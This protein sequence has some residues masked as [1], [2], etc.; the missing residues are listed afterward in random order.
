MWRCLLLSAVLLLPFAAQA[1]KNT[2]EPVQ[3]MLITRAGD[4]IGHALVQKDSLRIYNDIH[5]IASRHR[6]T[7]MAYRFVFNEPK[8]PEIKPAAVTRSDSLKVKKDD[9][10]QYDGAIIRKIDI[11]TLDPFGTSVSDSVPVTENLLKMAGNK[12]HIRTTRMTVRNQLL[13]RTGKQFDPLVA[14]ENERILRQSPYARDAKITVMPVNES[15]DS[16][17]VLVVVQDRWSLSGSAGLST[18]T[19]K[20]HLSEKNFMG[21]AHQ[22]TTDFYY[23]I[24]DR[25]GYRFSGSYAVPYIKN[26]FVTGSAF[27]SHSRYDFQRGIS[28]SRPFYSP[29]AKFSYGISA[30]RINTV[31]HFTID[32]ITASYPLDYYHQDGW[33]GRSFQ[34]L[35]G[36]SVA[37]RSTRAVVSTRVINTNYVRRAPFHVDT[38]E[39]NQDALFTMASAGVFNQRYYKDINIYKFGEPEDV[40]EGR[41]LSFTGGYQHREVASRYYA[42][43]RA[44]VAN[45]MDRIGYLSGSVEYGTFFNKGLA[46]DGVL[47]IDLSYFTDNWR[48]GRWAGRQFFFVRSSTGYNRE[49]PE[50]IT[51]NHERS[52]YGF[53]SD[54]LSGHKKVM[55]NTISVAYLPYKL[56][57]FRFAAIAFAGMG[58]IGNEGMIWDNK[59]H[60]AYGAG[61]LIRNDHLVINTFM[62]S[63]GIYPDV[64]GKGTVYKLNP[65][66]TYNFGFSDFI[67][68]RPD[69]VHYR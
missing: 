22:L 53:N 61:L 29:L 8:R 68:S 63:F 38:L 28:F 47:K 30:A 1:Q 27:Y 45:H 43:A 35:E 2:S 67:H 11:R 44:G 48:W 40:P 58:M 46:E 62:I 42:G 54:V 7:Y 39:L 20:L 3:P 6:L 26:T 21:L 37:R 23:N 16:V 66:G 5:R 64:P 50:R 56:I 24:P 34:L 60:Q 33:A 12:L 18:G 9:F 31:Q 17:D 25:E 51:L 49:R 57:G 41:I 10:A 65:I 15:C 59:V 36:R 69:V 32:T 14:R 13:L 55:I 4:T 19:S 52:L